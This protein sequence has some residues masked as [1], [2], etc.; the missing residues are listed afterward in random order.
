LNI[1]VVSYAASTPDLDDRTN[2]PYF[3]RTVPSDK[4]QA[5]AM[6]AVIQAMG[7]EY[8]DILFVANNYGTKGKDQFV[9]VAEENGVCVGE[10]MPISETNADEPALYKTVLELKNRQAKIVVF[11]GIDTRYSDVVKILNSG[12]DYGD[13]IFLA[14]EEWGTKQQ[15][16]LD[17]GKAARGTLTLDLASPQV[18]TQEFR[19]YML[20]R[21][22]ENTQYN[23]WFSEFWQHL[24]KCNI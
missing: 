5:E 3:I 21:N 18:E 11:F 1:P 4:D 6:L 17:G 12:Q 9:R 24:F 2:F 19:T 7:W 16:L 22:L 23:P 14:S 20:S 10:P 13:F 15:L 8:V